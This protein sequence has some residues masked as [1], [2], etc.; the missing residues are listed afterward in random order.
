MWFKIIE[1]LTGMIQ[2][3]YI[4]FDN[5]QIFSRNIIL[6]EYSEK[7][8]LIFLH[9]SWGCTEMWGDFPEKLAKT[10]G[11]NALVYDRRGYGKSSEFDPKPRNE[12]Y[13]HHEADFLVRLM[14]ELHISKAILYGHSD[15]AT[16]SLIAGATYPDRFEGLI[17]ESAHTF[18]EEEGKKTVLESREK[19]KH[20]SLLASLTKFH[21]FKTEELFKRWHEAWL[22]DLLK[23]WT[24]VPLL[25]KITCPALAMRGENDP[26]DT[27]E[28][29]NVLKK[30]ISNITAALI[31]RASH[32]PRNENEEE[33]FRLCE[34]FLGSYTKLSV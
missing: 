13:L 24:I 9:D 33:T 16:I 31:P 1:A 8:T 3:N 29:L 15:G 2:D 26:Y 18:I 23:N 10:G 6:N 14:D 4:L 28:Q 34:E 22:S 25:K 30:N 27:V 11:L 5:F 20:N 21:G 7:P 19:A 12:Y 17:L 32:C